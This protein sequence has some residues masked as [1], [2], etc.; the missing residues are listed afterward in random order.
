MA[1]SFS[2][3]HFMDQQRLERAVIIGGGYIGHEMAD[4]LT[5]KGIAV[6]PMEFAPE[7]LT[8]LDPD[9]GEIISAELQSN[10]NTRAG[11]P[12]SRQGIPA[13]LNPP[14]GKPR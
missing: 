14:C 11:I 4:A 10:A 6:T 7:V 1:D 12:F 13:R 9:L 3:K 8:T 2:V 5:H